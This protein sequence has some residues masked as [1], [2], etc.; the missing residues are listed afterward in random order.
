MA[1]LAAP[2]EA[3]RKPAAAGTVLCVNEDDG[4]IDMGI[5]SERASDR[6]L[7]RERHGHR[8]DGPDFQF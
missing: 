8:L 6:L 1:E 4:E 5:G 3:H 2:P 7:Q